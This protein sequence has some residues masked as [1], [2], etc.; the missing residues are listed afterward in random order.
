VRERQQ[1]ENLVASLLQVL[2]FVADEHLA[3]ISI[4]RTVLDAR[5][6][7]AGYSII[8]SK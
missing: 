8:A 5:E 7:S 2:T 6:T 1:E 3:V 4:I